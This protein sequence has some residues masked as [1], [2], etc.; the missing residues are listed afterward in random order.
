MNF[1][2]KEN[3]GKKAFLQT[4]GSNIVYPNAENMIVMPITKIMEMVMSIQVYLILRMNFDSEENARRKAP[5]ANPRHQYRVYQ[6][7]EH[8]RRANNKKN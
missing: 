3:C 7:G 4:Q 2:Y 6:C 1:Y 8:Y 5:L